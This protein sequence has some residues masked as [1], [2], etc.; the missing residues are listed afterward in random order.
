[1]IKRL[2]EEPYGIFPEDSQRDEEETL[3]ISGRAP[4]E[5]ILTSEGLSILSLFSLDDFAEKKRVRRSC[6]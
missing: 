4:L 5:A 6:P 1:M 2:K 3:W